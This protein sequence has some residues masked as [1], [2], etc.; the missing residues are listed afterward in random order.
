MNK[1]DEAIEVWSKAV[2]PA[3]NRFITEQE[4]KAP[5]LVCFYCGSSF[6]REGSNP[7]LNETEGRPFCAWCS[8]P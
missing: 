4:N 2:A 8:I 1:L 3:V 6:Y 7:L 5:N